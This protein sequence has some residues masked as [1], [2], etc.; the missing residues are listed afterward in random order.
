VKLLSEIGGGGIGISFDSLSSL[1][2]FEMMIGGGG[3]PGF[4]GIGVNGCWIASG[5]SRCLLK[6]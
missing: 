6:M 1:G 2:S 3:R 5:N 4:P